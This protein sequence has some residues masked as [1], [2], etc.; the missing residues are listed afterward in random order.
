M[1]Q[2]GKRFRIRPLAISAA[3]RRRSVCCSPALSRSISAA[4]CVKRADQNVLVD[5]RTP[6]DFLDL[7]DGPHAEERM[8]AQLEEVLAAID[9]AD[10]EQ[11]LPQ[12]G[13]PPLGRRAGRAFAGARCRHGAGRNLAWEAPGDRPC[14]WASSAVRS[15]DSKSDGTMNSGNRSVT[16]VA[17]RLDVQNPLDD[18]GHDVRDQPFAARRVVLRM[19][20]RFADRRMRFEHGFDLAQLD[21]MAADFHLVV[22]SAQKS[23]A[24]SG[25]SRTRSPVR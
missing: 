10:F 12:L 4:T 8:A 23:T 14:R 2:R 1:N 24:P 19:H 25:R 20:D 22:Q 16:N 17:E 18:L 3:H 9:L 11:L 15:S 13:Q 21:A 7:A 6:N 5:S